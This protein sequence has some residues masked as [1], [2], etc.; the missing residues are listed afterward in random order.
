MKIKNKILKAI[1]KFNGI[2][3]HQFFL[4]KNIPI[5]CRNVRILFCMK[6]KWK[7]G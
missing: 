4:Y 5:F 6:N 7:I 1:E 3:K 2:K